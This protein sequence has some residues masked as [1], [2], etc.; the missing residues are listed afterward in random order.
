MHFLFRSLRIKI[1]KWFHNNCL[2]SNAS[3]CNLITRSTSPIEIQIDNTV[4]SSV[5]RVKRLVHIDVRLNFDYHVSQICKKVSRKIHALSRE[6]K[7]MDQNKRKM[8]MKAFR[9]SQFSYCLWM[10]HNRN[11]GNRVNEIHKRALRF[12]YKHSPYLSFDKLLTK[13]TNQ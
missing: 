13:K 11:N 1:F 6:C 7:Y 3:K 10:F 9:N 2:K 4:I 5:N 8:L 12:V